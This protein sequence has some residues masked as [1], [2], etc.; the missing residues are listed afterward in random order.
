MTTYCENCKHVFE[1][2]GPTWTWLCMMHKR[3][4]GQ[5]FVTREFWDD[6]PPY[7]RCHTINHGACPNYEE[8]D[9]ES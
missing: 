5:G 2:K 3:T 7:L 6:D 4:T 9:A 8:A 1:K